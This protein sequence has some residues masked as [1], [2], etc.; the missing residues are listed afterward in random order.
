MSKHDPEDII[1]QLRQAIIEGHPDLGLQDAEA[2]LYKTIAFSLAA[3]L[4]TAA[5][6]NDLDT[7][8]D[9]WS[10]QLRKSFKFHPNGEFE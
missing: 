5:Y 2:D 10:Q 8:I 9:L 6:Y 7:Q 4:S 3:I 1:N